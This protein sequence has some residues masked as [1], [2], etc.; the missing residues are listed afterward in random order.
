MK[1]RL[2]NMFLEFMQRET[3]SGI[4]LLICT[5]IALA[6]ANSPWAESY[7]HFL[8]QKI[9]LGWGAYSLSMSLLHWLNDGLMAIFFF[10]VGMEI[11]REL[12]VGELNSLQKA[13]LPIAAAFGGMIVPALIYTAFNYGSPTMAGWGIP[14]AT[15]IAFAL[16]ILSLVGAK[17]A[18]RGLTVFLAALAIADDLGAILV[19]AIFYTAHLSWL[20]LLAALV[21]FGLLLILNKL[22]VSTFVPYLILGLL[23][24]FALLK[25]GIHATIAGVLLGMAMPAQTD[26]RTEPLLNK[27]EHTL[28]P[29]VNFLIM[30]LFALGNAGVSIGFAE[31]KTAVTHPVSIGVFAGLLIGKQV[32]IFSASWLL[33][34]GKLGSLPDRVTFKHLHGA[35]ILGGIGFTMSMFVA[36]LAFK[37]VTMLSMAKLGIIFAS[38]TAAIAGVLRLKTIAPSTKILKH[39]N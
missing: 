5:V 30:P 6:I 39:D 21:V 37:D 10:L 36:T 1:K 14:M 27:V 17:H 20:A 9:T 7:D 32:G 38:T 16:G 29:W 8:H 4:L 35:S 19:I 13:A 22:K 2:T 11:K 23:L 34:R 15:D 12:V 3:S 31:L 26:D 18:P 33:I 28:G 24:W 25:S